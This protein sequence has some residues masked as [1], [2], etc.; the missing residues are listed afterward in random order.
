[1]MRHD[2]FH[3]PDRPRSA[4]YDLNWL[5]GLDMGPHPL[6]LLED[7]T[8][9]LH[10]QPGMRV[11]DL[12]SGQGATSVFLAR[13]FGVR[14]WAADLWVPA[15]R[16]AATFAE[17]GVDDQVRAV[18]TEARELS[19]DQDSFDAVV[20]IDAWEYFGNEPRYL[21]YLLGFLR[22]GGQLGIAAA[23]LAV[24]PTDLTAVPGYVSEFVG[25][26]A[27]A[28]H[29]PHWYADQWSTT[30][31]V[32]V[33]AARFAVNGWHDWLVWA[34]AVADEVD[35]DPTVRMLEQDAGRC[36]GFALVTA[37]KSGGP[38]QRSSLDAERE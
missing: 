28:W 9:D 35:E 24:E 4:G 10:L 30:E 26:Q 38:E 15:D 22:P 23:A 25:A 21:S 5:L 11:L 29:P 34:R 36:L 19:F 32:D 16:A 8:T 6:W 12:G 27:L 14:V 2:D 33:V 13:E 18:H 7:L 1:M 20:C 3:R 17:Q 37:T 31:G